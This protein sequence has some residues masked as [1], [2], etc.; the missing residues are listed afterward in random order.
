MYTPRSSA[1]IT[2]DLV[3]R[4]VARTTLTDVSEGSVILAL[5]STFAEQIAES[6]VRLAQIRDQFTLEGASG[7]DLD[8]R[9]EEIGMTRLP[10][11]RATGTVRVTRTATTSALTIEAGAVFSGTN[12]E[13][14]FISTTD[15]VMQIGV[16]EIDLAIQA[17]VVGATGNVSARTIDTLVDVP[18]AIISVTQGV[19]LSNG[20]DEESDGNLR[21]RA[22]RH[23]NSL[24]RC[25]PVAL[26]NLALG[27]TASDNTRA[28][29]ATLYEPPDRLG[30]CELLIDDGSGLGDTAVTRAGA[31]VSI[32]LTATRGQIIG[33]EAPL[34]TAPVV[35]VG[36][37]G[38]VRG[39]DYSVS[40]ERGLIH[41]L[42]GSSVAEGD[43]VEISGYT[44]YTGL[45]AE[46]QSA[47]EGD[48]GDVSSGYRPAGISVRV[49][50][51]PVQ[52]IDLDVLVVIAT[53]AN[54][55]TVTDLVNAEVSAYLSALGAGAPAIIASVVRVVMGVE[56][57]LNVSVLSAGS[58]NTSPDIYPLTPRT[59]LR[60][61]T[62]RT[63][64]S[65]TTG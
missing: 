4:L 28:T 8:E 31:N 6:D 12:T 57:V 59:V 65:T 48:A 29:T 3:A 51:A 11:T 35:S 15:T 62:I 25:Q 24:A 9:A 34:A 52:R 32:T 39:T 37:A 54:L 18:D 42:E 23:L 46:L 45:V 30:E 63:I 20:A 44:V 17:S 1:E 58:A 61:G 26:E 55:T 27:F 16:S 60:A 5:M 33:I 56:N 10:A 19:A 13:V 38:L 64:T 47:I 53:G 14:T 43:T 41:I 21:A 49:L 7:T 36:G 2:R 22:I 50:P 40:F